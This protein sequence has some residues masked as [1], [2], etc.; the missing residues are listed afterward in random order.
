MDRPIGMFDSGFGGLTVARAMIDLLPHED[1]VYIG[2]TA[3]YPYGNKPQADVREYARQLAWSLVKDFDAKAI[4]VACNTAAAAAL[5][6]LAAELPVPVIGPIAAGAK[7]LVSATRSGR[8]GVIGTV[9]TVMSGVYDRA[10]SKTRVPVV[11]TTAAC[12]GF[13][14][15]VERG[16]ASGDEI[17]IL[18]D[19]MLAPVKAASVDTLLLAC[20][21]YTALAR[22]I[23]QAMGPSVTLVSSADETAFAARD[24]LGELGLL[25]SAAPPDV[26]H[27][28]LCSGEIS[29]IAD[30]GDRLFGPE[31]ASA[32]PWIAPAVGET[33]PAPPT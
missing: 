32:D 21:H 17:A 19:R 23:G 7:A 12:P 2:D 3:R 18:A 5:D 25:R 9:G 15:F 30:L 27:Q 11:L 29:W 6:D 16:H 26:V 10:I 28:F 14:E 31:L 4:V 22:V 33:V 1:I 20:T 13:V 8:V 24:Q